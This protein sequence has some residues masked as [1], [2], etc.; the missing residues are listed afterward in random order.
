MDPRKTI[1]SGPMTRFQW[2]VVA[3]MIG[4]IALDGFD[5]LSISF[6]SPGIAAEWGIDRGALGLV[7]S[8]ELIGMSA[9]SILFG[10][11]AD[12][13][14]RR[15]TI[16]ACLGVIALGMFGAST[17]TGVVSLSAWRVGTGLG[18][19]GMLAAT[20]AATA[21]VANGRF[22]SLCVVMMAAGY[23][24]GNVIGGSVAAQL[25]AMYDWRAIF[26]FGA[27]VAALFVPLV[28]FRAPESI[29]FLMHRRPPGALDRVNETLARMG[30]PTIDA[31]PE[32][33]TQREKA[34]LRTLMKGQHMVPTLALTFVYFAHIMT[35][36]FILKWIPKIVADMG[37]EPSAAAGVLVWASVGGLLGSALLGLLTIRV[38]VFWLTVV[39]MAASSLMVIW[40]GQSQSDLASLSITAA[41]AGFATNA[42]VVGLYAVVAAAFPTA[43]RASATGVVIGIGRGGS[44]L[45]P[46]LAGFLFAAGYGLGTVALLMALGSLAAALVL[47]LLVRHAIAQ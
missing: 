17:A 29:E 36:Y 31:L 23:P 4:L 2:S 32:V 33:E 30:K 1:E 9:G 18:L 24:L 19:G 34:G 14:G 39:A 43:L 22:R 26:Q 46:A 10:R 5:V 3:I 8:M 7:L 11:L 44:A 38:R 21:E 16:L 28:W 20:N 47:L 41:A 27:I 42:G 37:F 40:F 15:T 45:A 13:Y 35:F 25:L 12:G 6:A